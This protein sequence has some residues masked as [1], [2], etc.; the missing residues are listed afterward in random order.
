MDRIRFETGQEFDCE[1]ATISPISG[2]FV[3]RVLRQT[4]ETIRA[5][6]DGSPFIVHSLDHEDWD[7]RT[8]TGFSRIRDI[9]DDNGV[10]VV[11]LEVPT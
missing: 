4:E 6:F 8:Y 9:R 10:M 5:A 11:R 1:Y 7:D 2:R 3:A